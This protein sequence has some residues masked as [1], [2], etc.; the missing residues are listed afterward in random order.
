MGHFKLAMGAS[1]SGMNNP[2]GDPFPGKALQFL[3][4]MYILQQDRTIL[5]GRNGMLIITYGRTVIAGEDISLNVQCK[6][7]HKSNCQ[8]CHFFHF[9]PY[10]FY[11]YPCLRAQYYAN[12]EF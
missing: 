7:R 4:E 2:L 12:H 11:V 5:T 10:F 3:D 1:T 6:A 9:F 8:F